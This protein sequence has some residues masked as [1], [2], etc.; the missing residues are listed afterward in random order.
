MLKNLFSEFDPDLKI[1]LVEGKVFNIETSQIE[2][3]KNTPGVIA[4]SDVIEEN[5]LIKYAEK[6]VPAKIKGVSSEFSSVTNIQ[7]IMYSGT[8]KLQESSYSYAVAGIGLAAQLNMGVSFLQPLS[9][10]APRRTARINM[11][12]PETAFNQKYFYLSGIFALK[13]AQ[14]DDHYLI[15][16][17]QEARSIFEYSPNEATSIELKVAPDVNIKKLQ[18]E[19]QQTLGKQFT[20]QNRNEQQESF[21][22]IMRIEKWISYL[23]LSFILLIAIFN[24]IGSL[25]MLIIEKQTDIIVLRNLGANKKQ[26]KSIFLFEGWLISVLGSFVGIVIGVFLCLLQEK[27]GLIG[28]QTA[29][30]NENFIINSYPVDLQFADVFLIFITVITMAFFAV[31]YPVKFIKIEQDSN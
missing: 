5:A 12:R 11:A 26:I 18:K 2:K 14:Y 27:F 20:V 4:F 23:I 10:Y 7:N 21:Y 3:I 24:I 29:T 19:I 1:T 28:L 15:I 6:Q 25:S 17:I 9:I 30:G 8:F 31:R 16:P 22:R 13:Q